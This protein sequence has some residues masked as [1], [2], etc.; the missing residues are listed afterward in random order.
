MG[1]GWEI[2]R[3]REREDVFLFCFRGFV[4]LNR[5]VLGLLADA[6]KGKIKDGVITHWV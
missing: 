6:R 2:R 1:N 3:D 4:L 5:Y